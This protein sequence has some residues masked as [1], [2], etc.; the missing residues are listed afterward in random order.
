MAQCIIN[1][2]SVSVSGRSA[3]LTNSATVSY[4]AS[5]TLPTSYETTPQTGSASYKETSSSGSNWERKTRNYTRTQTRTAYT[6]KSLD[7]SWRFSPAGS[8]SGSSGTTNVTSLKAGSSNSVVGNLTVTCT[9]VKQPQKRTKTWQTQNTRYKESKTVTK[10]I[11]KVVDGKTVTETVTETVEEW[12]PWSGWIG[13]EPS[14]WPSSWSNNGSSTSSPN[15]CKATN[16][17]S[18]TVY[19]RPGTFSGFDFTKDTTIQEAINGLSAT[20]VGNWVSHCNKYSHWYNQNGTDTANGCKVSSGDL[21]T[22]NWYNKCVAAIAAHKPSTI[23]K[24]AGTNEYPP[25]TAEA[26]KKL[27]TAIS[28]Y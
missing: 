14:S 19:T 10:T 7:Y 8:A 20:K 12:G 3:V 2:C 24:E 17:N 6:Y 28:T 5:A 16:S 27:G 21:I 22:A 25:I 13:E 18:V 4:S 23:T 26:I 11:S 15:S 9:E 1:S